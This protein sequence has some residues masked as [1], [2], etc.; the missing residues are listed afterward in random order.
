MLCRSGLFDDWRV[1]AVIMTSLRDFRLEQLAGGSG[2]PANGA[3]INVSR[4]VIS[5][6]IDIIQ[7]RRRIERGEIY[8]S[9]HF[10]W[11]FRFWQSGR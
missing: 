6:D 8:V 9:E 11:R 5:V 4:H 2:K 10:S 1:D 3:F 7:E